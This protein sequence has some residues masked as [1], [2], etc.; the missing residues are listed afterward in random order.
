MHRAAETPVA[1]GTSPN[2][3]T[4]RMC[5]RSA[6]VEGSVEALEVMRVG[7]R[8]SIE[9]AAS[10]RDDSGAPAGGRAEA[11]GR[12]R[13]APTGIGGKEAPPPASAADA[14]A[15]PAAGGANNV[16]VSA[17]AAAAKT[18]RRGCRLP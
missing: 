15:E 1:A 11:G 2:R 17:I 8:V 3:V 7:A 9:R 5:S 6:R 18:A 4:M 10:R 16:A 14:P 12:W 13:R